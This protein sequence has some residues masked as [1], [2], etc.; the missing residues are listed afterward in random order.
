MR[1]ED[2]PELQKIEDE[3]DIC[4]VETEDW[5]EKKAEAEANA[6]GTSAF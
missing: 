1:L 2:D 6:K 5:K 3:I 4:N